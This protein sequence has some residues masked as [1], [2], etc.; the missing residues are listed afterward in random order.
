MWRELRLKFSYDELR[1]I[2]KRLEK[3]VADYKKRTP[4]EKK[5]RTLKPDIPK[6][7]KGPSLTFYNVKDDPGKLQ[8][9]R[10]GK[11]GPV[12]TV[13]QWNRIFRLEAYEKQVRAVKK[14]FGMT[15]KT[16]RSLVHKIKQDAR[17]RVKKLKNSKKLTKRQKRGLSQEKEERRAVALLWSLIYALGY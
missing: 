13:K 10:Y 1:D 4:K 12:V 14:G 9:Y 5:S 3:R 2:S 8:V 17:K 6:N 11:P 16:A 15:E 7:P